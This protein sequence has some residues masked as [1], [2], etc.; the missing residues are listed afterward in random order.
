MSQVD[1]GV[2]TS[3]VVV[4]THD[5]PRPIPRTITRGSEV[6][7]CQSAMICTS[8]GPSIVGNPIGG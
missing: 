6:D 5:C 2:F 3:G 7:A 8:H 1:G 4:V